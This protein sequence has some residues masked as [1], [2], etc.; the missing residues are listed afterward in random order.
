MLNALEKNLISC[1]P[2]RAVSPELLIAYT[3]KP[4]YHEVVL[5]QVERVKTSAMRPVPSAPQAILPRSDMRWVPERSVRIPGEPGVVRVPAHWERRVSDHEV[6][7][8]PLSIFNPAE[9]AFHAIPAG[10]KEPPDRRRGP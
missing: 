4:I 8:P 10:T 1:F 6:R 5:T 9:G 7:V 2:F 3:I